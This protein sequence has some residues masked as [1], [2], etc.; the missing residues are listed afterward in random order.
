MLLNSFTLSYWWSFRHIYLILLVITDII[1]CCVTIPIF[2]FEFNNTIVQMLSIYVMFAIFLPTWL[3]FEFIHDQIR[4]F[5]SLSTRTLRCKYFWLN[6]FG[7]NLLIVPF[8]W[9]C[10]VIW[11]FVKLNLLNY[12]KHR[13]CVSISL[14]KHNSQMYKYLINSIN[15]TEIKYK[16]IAINYTTSKSVDNLQSL[17]LENYI[18]QK[19]E[20]KNTTKK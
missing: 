12:N 8:V 7:F 6:I 15:I 13:K 2:I 18:E 9:I 1:R 5:R 10:A 4:D 17:A 16:I 3:F 20:D 14:I 19:Y 11:Y